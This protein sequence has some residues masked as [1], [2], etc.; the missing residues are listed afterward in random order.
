M[1]SNTR[2]NTVADAAVGL[3]DLKKKVI[4]GDAAKAADATLEKSG[5]GPCPE[6]IGIAYS[7]LCA[8]SST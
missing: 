5:K 7:L 2:I 1:W 3:G 6:C 4:K 8:I